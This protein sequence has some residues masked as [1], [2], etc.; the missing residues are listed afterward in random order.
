VRRERRWL[1]DVRVRDLVSPTSGTS[2]PVTVL[3]SR[4]RGG[5]AG[6]VAVRDGRALLSTRD[7]RTLGWVLVLDRAG[8]ASDWLRVRRRG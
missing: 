7:G 3:H 2:G 8:N 6:T 4:R 5:S 1:L